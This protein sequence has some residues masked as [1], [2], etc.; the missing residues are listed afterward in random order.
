[1]REVYWARFAADGTLQ[2]VG[3]EHVGPATGVSLPEPEGGRWVAAGRGLTV[4]PALAERC[5]EA[6]ASLYADLL[7]RADEI[8]ALAR[9]LVTQGQILPPDQA[10]PVY[11]RDHVVTTAL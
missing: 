11:V 10:L 1:M 7:P 8:L 9:P 3:E 2:P 5:R 4:A 6:G